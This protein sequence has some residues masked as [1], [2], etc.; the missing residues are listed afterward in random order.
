MTSTATIDFSDILYNLEDDFGQTGLNYL[1]SQV[2]IT[3]E[4]RNIVKNLL[5]ERLISAQFLLALNVIEDWI[6]PLADILNILAEDEIKLRELQEE[7]QFVLQKTKI[8]SW[9]Q[10]M[11]N[12]ELHQVFDELHTVKKRIEV[13]R[14]EIFAAAKRSTITQ[15]LGLILFPYSGHK[16]LPEA[17]KYAEEKY[18]GPNVKYRNF[19]KY[20]DAIIFMNGA[21]E[22]YQRKEITIDIN[23]QEIVSYEKYF[24]DS[25][26]NI[27]KI[28]NL[29]FEAKSGNFITK[30]FTL[31]DINVLVSKIL[32]RISGL[33]PEERTMFQNPPYYLQSIDQIKADLVM[34]WIESQLTD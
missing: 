30:G 29:Y 21:R 1:I 18:Y 27:Q 22:I 32:K 25:D 19:D 9:Q 34:Q 5:D 17:I 31:R 33:T 6:A 3:K 23:D 20:C 15:L 2:N 24:N 10:A 16:T 7:A 13:E 12:P 4:A 26:S 28:E 14:E 8:T 11:N